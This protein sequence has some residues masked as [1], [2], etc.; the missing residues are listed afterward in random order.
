M[1]LDPLP[2]KMTVPREAWGREGFCGAPTR[3]GSPPRSSLLKNRYSAEVSK[4][5]SR[6]WP[7]ARHVNR[8][9]VSKQSDPLQNGQRS[10]SAAVISFSSQAFNVRSWLGPVFV[11]LAKRTSIGPLV[12]TEFNSNLLTRLCCVFTF[13]TSKAALSGSLCHRGW[14]SCCWRSGGIKPKTFCC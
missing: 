5:R 4:G 11:N 10:R 7:Q 1:F 12:F 14:C 9:L 2:P 13:A 8:S 6:T 3:V